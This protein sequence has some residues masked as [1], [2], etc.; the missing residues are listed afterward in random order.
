MIRIL[1]GIQPTGVP[2]LGNYFGAIYQWVKFAKAGQ[3]IINNQ[4]KQCE[5]PIFFL[6][7]THAL[8]SQRSFDKSTLEEQN[9]TTLASLLACGLNPDNSI[10][11]KQGD[12]LE[13]YYLHTILHRFVT[14]T[15]LTHMI[16]Y[17]DRATKVGR[18]ELT[19]A[20][21][22]YPVLQAADIL[23]YRPDFVPIGED[24]VQHLD[25]T[26][27]IAEKF[28]KI[29]KTDL[30]P[31]P[32]PIF[33]ESIHSRRIKSL[34]NPAKK[35]SKSDPNTKAAITIVDSPDLILEK[36]KKAVTDCRSD[37]SFEPE[38]R[39]EIANLVILYHL[40]SGLSIE[41]VVSQSKNLTSAE[42]K[43][44]LAD[45]IIDRLAPIRS[46]YTR[47]IKERAYLDQ[48]IIDGMNAARAIAS[49]TMAKVI[50][51]METNNW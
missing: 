46:E 6:A 10:L 26:R 49:G 28:N 4:S 21:L 23:L 22:V 44:K 31:L 48:V 43:I 15:K 41:D 51:Y 36:C 1:S 14:T 25:L 7:S 11:F 20:L 40:T 29:F 50:Q 18:S 2:H 38:T 16:Q 27:D 33:H 17:K 8:M 45:V 30:F 34:R 9:L 35:M 3:A 37:I 47:L 13:N 5:K 12:V 39:P 32:Q 19:N 42:F 24:Q